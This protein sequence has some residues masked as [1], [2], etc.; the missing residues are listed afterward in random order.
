MVA[1]AHRRP[2]GEG[3]EVISTPHLNFSVGH[4]KLSIVGFSPS[5]RTNDKYSLLYNEGQTKRI[6]I[7]AMK[8]NRPRRDFEKERQDWVCRSK[9]R[10]VVAFK[11]KGA[12][13]DGKS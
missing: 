3:R 2:D 12:W 5:D 1:I 9:E 7:I 4:R 10:L 6:F 13:M 8:W 11:E